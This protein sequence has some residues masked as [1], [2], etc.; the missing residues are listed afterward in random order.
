MKSGDDSL[1]SAESRRD[2][3]ERVTG[4]AKTEAVLRL[5]RG[6]SVEAISQE[7]GVTIPRI[8][9]WKNRFTEAGAAELA[10]R[11][12]DSSKSWVAKHS[13]SI[14]QWIWLLLALV[15]IISILAVIMQRSP[16]E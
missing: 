10:R 1:P 7:L 12:N 13:S 2:H 11:K 14:W 6:E 16:Q 5:L 8:E 3:Y 15:V 9:R 4:R